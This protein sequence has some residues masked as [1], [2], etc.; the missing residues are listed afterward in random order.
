MPTVLGAGVDRFTVNEPCLCFGAL[1]R[2]SRS[3]PVGFWRTGT[4]TG[5]STT[6]PLVAATN[7]AISILTEGSRWL[8]DLAALLECDVQ[9]GSAVFTPLGIFERSAQHS[10][11]LAMLV[12]S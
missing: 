10:S 2:G 1:L 5:M 7:G 9:T 11:S 4:G 6:C 3:V 8:S 12:S